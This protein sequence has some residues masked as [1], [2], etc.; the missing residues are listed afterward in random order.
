MRIL[1]LLAAAMLSVLAF[2]A[3]AQAIVFG[4]LDQGAH[5]NVGAMMAEFDGQL[6]QLCTGT[7]IAPTVFLTASHCTAYLESVGVDPHDVYVTFD[8]QLSQSPTLIRGTYHTNPL[9][10]SGGQNDTYDVAVIVLD[11]APAGIAPA[12]LPTAGLLDQLPL[13]DQRFV[14]VGYGDVRDDKATGPHAI[15]WDGE[16]RWADQGFRSLTKAWLNLSMNPSVGSGGTCYGDSGGP[17]FLGATDVVVSVTVTGDANC[18][19]TDVTYRMD[20]PAAR[21]FLGQFVTLP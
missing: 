20:T 12:R 5:P 6:Y 15:Y 8:E 21:A 3:P 16:R 1:R 14:A 4:Q 7:L 9:F 19:A 18:R 2:S 10:A 11:A 17:H 13:K